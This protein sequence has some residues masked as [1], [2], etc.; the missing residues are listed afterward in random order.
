MSGFGGSNLDDLSLIFSYDTSSS[1]SYKGAPT[2]NWSS[3][4]TP[5]TVN[6]TNTDVSS[7]SDAGPVSN[8]TTWKL[9]KFGGSNQW[10]GWESNY[11]G[12]WTGNSGDIWTTSYWYKTTQ[13]AGLSAFQVGYFYLSNWSAPYNTSILADTSSIIADGEWHYNYTITRFNENYSNAII[14]DGPAW[15]YSSSPGILFINGLQWEKKPYP[16]PF[17]TDVR[18]ATD[19]CLYSLNTSNRLPFATGITAGGPLNLS[20]VAFTD[21]KL[22][23]DGTD[24]RFDT[25][26]PWLTPNASYEFVINCKG[27]VSTYNMFA[28][29]ILPYFGVHN[30]NCISYSDLINGNQTFFTSPANSIQYNKYYHVVCTRFYDSGTTM[31]IF[32]NGVKV[33]ET[34]AAGV[35]TEYGPNHYIGDGQPAQWYP[36]YGEVPIVNMYFKKTLSEAEVYEKYLNYKTRFQLT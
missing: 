13:P 3:G 28:G 6:G 30:G 19:S 34:A 22:N 14:V 11:G 2:Q 36:F 15:G 20:N 24:D 12:I 27:N 5:W 21:G 25:G 32:I 9:Q 4:I 31:K 29:S 16:T 35:P 33:A 18:S 17:T 23:F 1:R 7:T 8:S 10:N 26:V